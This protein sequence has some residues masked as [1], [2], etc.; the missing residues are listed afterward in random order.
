MTSQ[1]VCTGPSSQ[2]PVLPRRDS[3][4]SEHEGG[5]APITPAAENLQALCT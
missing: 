1:Y 3:E 5:V 4:L 2:S